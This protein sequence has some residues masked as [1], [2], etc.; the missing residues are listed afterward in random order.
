MQAKPQTNTSDL[1]L[2]GLEGLL[3]SSDSQEGSTTNGAIEDVQDWTVEETSRA[4]GLTRGAIIRRL[5]DGILPGYKVKRS[6][7]WV[8][9]VKPIWLGEQRKATRLMREELR[10][11][12]PESEQEETAQ[13]QTA[14]K[15]NTSS[16]VEEVKDQVQEIV[17]VLDASEDEFLAP[18]TA[19][20][21]REVIQLKTK[22]EM[23]EYQ[24][25]DTVAKLETAN[26]RIGYLEAR[27]EASQEQLKMLTDSRRAEPW[28]QRWRQWFTSSSQ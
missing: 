8:W 23:T 11:D 15:T 21:V 16:P 6:Y 22:L 3:D 25:Q 13:S 10:R 28:W 7:G 18:A 9:R 12:D 20:S 5:E 26:Y 14:E 19:T 1:S 2:D 4:L 24:F 17:E 27:L